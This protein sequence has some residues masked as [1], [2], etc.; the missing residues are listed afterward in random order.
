MWQR[1]YVVKKKL[2]AA[3]GWQN[4]PLINKDIKGPIIG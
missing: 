2:Q 4:I 1:E 3:S